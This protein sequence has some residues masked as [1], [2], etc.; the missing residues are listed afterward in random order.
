VENDVGIG[1]GI[2]VRVGGTGLGVGP[3]GRTTER[4]GELDLLLIPST[5]VLK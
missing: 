5:W 4:S 3:D 2:G 1:V